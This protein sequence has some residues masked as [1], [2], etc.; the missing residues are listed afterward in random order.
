V[1]DNGIGIP[2]EMHS[3]I[4][5]MF[6]AARRPGTDGETPFGLGLS[7]VR[8]IVEAHKGKILV[9]SEVGKGTT[10]FIQLPLNS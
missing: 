4:F 10:F 2:A 5:D 1:K 6:T 3:K 7:I 9:E 8:K